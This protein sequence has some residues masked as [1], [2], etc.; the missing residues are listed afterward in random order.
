MEDSHIAIDIPSRPDH[1]FV[2][3][4]AGHAG[5]GAAKYAVENIINFIEQSASLARVSKKGLGMIQSLSARL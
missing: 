3:V 4:W 5:A 1:L 2:G